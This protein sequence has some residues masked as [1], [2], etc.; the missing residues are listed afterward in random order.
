M[1]CRGSDNRYA[2]VG[3]KSKGRTVR[4]GARECRRC[5]GSEYKRSNRARRRRGRER[6]PDRLGSVQVLDG[7]P[8][9]AG[10]RR[11]DVLRRSTRSN[12]ER[13]I[14]RRD[15]CCPLDGRLSAGWGNPTQRHQTAQKRAPEGLGYVLHG[16]DIPS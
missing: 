4:A 9:D 3:P 2:T 6:N 10:R 8:M 14:P 5:C 1:P 15:V 7:E 13:A 11:D 16:E 12:R